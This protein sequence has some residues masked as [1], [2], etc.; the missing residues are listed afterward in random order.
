MNSD[1]PTTPP[2]Q[3][4]IAWKEIA[5]ILRNDGGTLWVLGEMT[6]GPGPVATT[7]GG[8]QTEIIGGL[9]YSSA[10]ATAQLEP[11][12]VVE[13]GVLS[14]SMI[15]ASFKRGVAYPVLVRRIVNGQP[16]D[17]LTSDQAGGGMRAS[18]ISL[19]ATD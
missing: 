17:L 6:E 8:G 4:D 11:A 3:D 12:F 15:E 1:A 2:T 5:P 10:G 9:I 18:L 14:V 13:D 16:S 7:S 19:F